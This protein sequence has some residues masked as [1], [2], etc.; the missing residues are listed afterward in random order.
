MVHF[1]LPCLVA[2]GYLNWGYIHQFLTINDYNLSICI[3]VPFISIY[4]IAMTQAPIDWRYLPYPRLNFR[5][6]FQGISPEHVVLY[7]TVPPFQDPGIPLDSTAFR[8]GEDIIRG[9]FYAS[10]VGR[11]IPAPWFAYGVPGMSSQSY[12]IR[13]GLQ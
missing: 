8:G 4:S 13:I 10:H 11:T 3:V 6:M 1:P 12:V 2:G 7:G 9:R 5:P